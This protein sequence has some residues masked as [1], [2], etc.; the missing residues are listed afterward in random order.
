MLKWIQGGISAVTGIAEPEYGK[1]FIHPVTG[2]VK[3]KQPFHVAE[4]EDFHWLSPTHTNVE[5]MTFY[6]TDLKQGYIGFA[7]VIHSNVVGI[8]TTAQFTFRLYNVKE[9]KLNVWTSTKLANFRIDGPNFYADD[10]SIEMNEA[11]SQVRFQS[12]VNPASVVDLTF[13]RAVPGVKVGANGTTYYGDNLEQPWGSMRHVFWPRNFCHGTLKVKPE[14]D[15]ESD[16]EAEKEVPVQEIVFEKGAPVFSMF[17]M[18]LQGMKPHHAAKAW[19]FLNFQSETHSAVL[20][21]FTTPKSYANTKICVGILCDKKDIIAVT[22]D[23]N[24]EHLDTKIDSVG[25]PVPHKIDVSF[26]GVK[27]DVSDE[28]VATASPVTALASGPLE[29]LVERVDVM[30]EIPSFVK[31]IVSGVAGTKPYIYQYANDFSLRV[32][33]AAPVSG[34]GWCEITFI[35]EAEEVT[36]ESYSET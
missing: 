19:N 33:D 30:S 24:F 12:S 25:W 15:S 5:T 17:V 4:R 34:T 3:D 20:M 11:G 21:E 23:N 10:L 1:D 35:S 31:N 8:H 29:Q 13:E 9:P 36:E 2:Q 27:S 16:T 32:D 22:I 7:Q 18:A 14:L 6:F 28:E 26:K